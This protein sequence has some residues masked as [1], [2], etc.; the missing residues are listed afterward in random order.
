MPIVETTH[1]SHEDAIQDFKMARAG[2]H[3]PTPS[4]YGSLPEPKVAT[5]PQSGRPRESGSASNR[6]VGREQKYEVRILHRFRD[7][8]IGS[9]L[10]SMAWFPAL[11]GAVCVFAFSAA[12]L[13][14]CHGRGAG[15][16]FALFSGLMA[17]FFGVWFGYVAEEYKVMMQDWKCTH[18]LLS[19]I[20]LLTWLLEILWGGAIIAGFAY[21]D[22]EAERRQECVHVVQ[23]LYILWAFSFAIIKCIAE[24]VTLR[25]DFTT[26]E[27]IIVF[28]YRELSPPQGGCDEE[29]VHELMYMASSRACKVQIHCLTT[30]EVFATPTDFHLHAQR[31][32]KEAVFAAE[33]ES[34]TDRVVHV[35]QP[36]FKRFWFV[37]SCLGLSLIIGL[38]VIG[39]WSGCDKQSVNSNL[40]SIT[41]GIWYLILGAYSFSTFFCGEQDEI[42]LREADHDI[43]CWP[44][45][46]VLMSCLT[47]IWGIMSIKTT[48][49]CNAAAQVAAWLVILSGI[50][51][52]AF[53]R[54][55]VNTKLLLQA[56]NWD[57]D[58][59]I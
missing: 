57:N 45:L 17:L 37:I 29:S 5:R 27:F 2:S 55:V 28:R 13:G 31:R 8:T 36:L 12:S 11:S 42:A 32:A 39:D 46:T 53:A 9:D 56:I 50:L 14:N 15:S 47:L 58:R 51:Q 52:C 40:Y 30:D 19:S 35:S 54:V 24:Q 33:S 4:D 34:R 3:A 21:R 26:Q 10:P 22:R 44:L 59:D 6:T 20:F 23:Y 25:W 43:G 1:S 18:I 38:I 49:H 16:D 48:G 7:W 41:C